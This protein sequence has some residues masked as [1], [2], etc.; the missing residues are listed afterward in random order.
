MNSQQILMLGLVVA[1]GAVAGYTFF[2]REPAPAAPKTTPEAAVELTIRAPERD[3][4]KW[5]LSRI[6]RDVEPIRAFTTEEGVRVQVLE[7]GEGQAVHL[8]RPIDLRVELY[9]LTGTK[10]Q[11]DVVRGLVFGQRK[12]GLEGFMDGLT[13]IRPYERRRI[14][15]PNERAHGA[16]TVGQAPPH[17]DLVY[18]V[19]WVYFKI[20]ELREGVGEEAREGSRVK[21][22]Y[23]GTLEDGTVFD[24]TG[25][26]E[27]ATFELKRGGVIDGFRIGI[28]G[29]KEGGERRIW[30]PGHMAYGAQGRRPKIGPWANLIFVVE[31]LEVLD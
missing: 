9:L 25:E 13:G 11:N 1:I 30:I 28:Q 15:V 7:E 10:I 24:Q 31:L 29:M 3:P 14:L 20:T 5:D 17:A 4:A 2:S 12:P 26:N 19:R 21:V 18:D 27:P 6:P 22:F 16:R 8:G 23:R